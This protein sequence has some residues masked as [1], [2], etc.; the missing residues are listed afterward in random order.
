MTSSSS[1]S[2][3]QTRKDPFADFQ[4]FD[5]LAD[6]NS[7]T[8]SNELPNLKINGLSTSDQSLNESEGLLNQTMYALSDDTRSFLRNSRIMMES[9]GNAKK[10]GNSNPSLNTK[11]WDSPKFQRKPPVKRSQPGKKT[12][13]EIAIEQ[14]IGNGHVSVLAHASSAPSLSDPPAGNMDVNCLSSKSSSDFNRNSSTTSNAQILEQVGF[15]GSKT[16]DTDPFLAISQRHKSRQNVA[17]LVA[18]FK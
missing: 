17:A 2:S 4:E 16:D 18:N 14:K 6:Q 10:L 3:A 13:R 8:N 7:P 1:S 15:E 5:Y 9:S 12:L 11:A